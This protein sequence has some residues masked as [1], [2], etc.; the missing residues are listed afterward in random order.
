MQGQLGKNLYA[1]NLWR[2]GDAQP[3]KFHES[4]EGKM[5]MVRVEVTKKGMGHLDTPCKISY[6]LLFTTATAITTGDGEVILS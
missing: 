4:A 3:G 6:R 2:T 5:A 1:N